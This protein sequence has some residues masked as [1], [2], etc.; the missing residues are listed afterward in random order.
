MRAL[1]LLGIC[2]ASAAQA[3]D[4]P[5]IEPGQSFS[6]IQSLTTGQ[7][8][9]TL[10]YAKAPQQYGELWLPESGGPFP[11][12]VFIHGGYW[13][14]AFDITHTHAASTA[15]TA[16]GYA[17]WSLEYRRIGDPGGGWPGTFDDISLGVDHLLELIDRY[18]LDISKVYLAG[19]S[20]GGH[21]AL[22]AAGRESRGKSTVTVA[23]VITLAGI[24]DL[25]AYAFGNSSCQR[26]VNQ[27]MGGSPQQ[28]PERY[29][30]ASPLHRL[31]TNVPVTLIQGTSDTIV[32]MSQA[33]AY[34]EAAKRS[35]TE[36]P[37][38]LRRVEDAGH[39]DLIHPGTDAWQQLLEAL[40]E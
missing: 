6:A 40:A 36:A 29:R 13:L 39:F 28:W 7:P 16:A 11:V 21:L 25:E 19:H 2:F 4:Y 37:T 26:A 14:N 33:E 35:A 31:P 15:L 12:V 34:Y 22:W 20:A 18:P 32:P 3:I 5:P 17:V 10:P 23:A 27:L 24:L 38:T 9:A 30:R 8:T 1:T